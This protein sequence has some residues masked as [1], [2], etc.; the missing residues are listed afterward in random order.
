M[1]DWWIVVSTKARNTPDHP[2]ARSYT[3]EE[4]MQAIQE[5]IDRAGD[6]PR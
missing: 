6:K 4:V 2:N 1:I 3:H 5:R